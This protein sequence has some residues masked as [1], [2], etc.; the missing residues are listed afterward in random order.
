[1]NLSDGLDNKVVQ[2]SKRLYRRGERAE[3]EGGQAANCNT[4]AA[5]NSEPALEEMQC[6]VT[7]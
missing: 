4:G 2:K 7:R 1:M 5:G 3:E 6:R